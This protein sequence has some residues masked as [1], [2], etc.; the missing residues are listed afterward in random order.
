MVP[1]RYFPAR[2]INLTNLHHPAHV[3]IKHKDVMRDRFKGLPSRQYFFN[4]QLNKQSE[5][6]IIALKKPMLALSDHY[7]L[8]GRNE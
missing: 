7:L 6:I 1:S 5:L 8:W 3:S 2:P 4:H